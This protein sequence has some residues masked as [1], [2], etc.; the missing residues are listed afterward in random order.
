MTDG[1]L[2]VFAGVSALAIRLAMAA[3][4]LAAALHAM[5]NWAAFSAI[6]QAYRLGPDGAARLA[7]R[8]VPPLEI[9]AAFL[10]ILP[11]TQMAGQVLALFLMAVFTA[12]IGINLARG[13]TDIECGC[14]GESQTI[15]GA[16]I[17]RNGVLT[18]CLAATLSVRSAWFA[19]ASSLV[20][21]VGLAAF[22]TGLYFASNQLLINAGRFAAARVG[23]AA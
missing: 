15:S 22:L 9:L 5:R 19:D 20:A 3:I 12:A 8:L 11:A 6:V 23:A 16:L 1:F 7:G 21:T 4:L 17:I 10:L 18:A 2:V 14:G 13:R